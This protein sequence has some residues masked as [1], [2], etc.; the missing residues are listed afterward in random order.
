MKIIFNG[1]VYYLVN[2]QSYKPPTL[3]DFH[4]HAWAA[5]LLQSKGYSAKLQRFLLLWI[6]GGAIKLYSSE[7]R[8]LLIREHLR[9]AQS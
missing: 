6:Q 9:W 1:S 3:S 4:H 2:E 7:A 8:D 5:P